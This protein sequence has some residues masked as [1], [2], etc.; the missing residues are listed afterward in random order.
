MNDV[1]NVICAR[2]PDPEKDPVGHKLVCDLMIH[3]PCGQANPLNVCMDKNGPG[4]GCSAYYP[5]TFLDKTQMIDGWIQYSRVSPA[6][7]GFTGVVKRW[8]HAKK[9]YKNVTVDDSMVVPYNM[10]LLKTF[11]C[12]M[13]VEYVLSATSVK[14]L[15]KYTLK[16]APPPALVTHPLLPPPPSPSPPPPCL[17]PLPPVLLLFLPLP[18]S[19]S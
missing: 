13:N 3:G 16:Y 1:D 2:I 18:G 15:F 4:S 11:A 5:K 14:Y 10:Y 17:I 9:A 6:N 19:S 8:D 12:H 7:G